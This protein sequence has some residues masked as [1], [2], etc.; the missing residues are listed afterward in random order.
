LKLKTSSVFLSTDYTDGILSTALNQGVGVR[1][2]GVA[3]KTK[4]S[5]RQI[6]VISGDE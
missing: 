3:K 6:E 1:A 4:Q 5:T 2:Q